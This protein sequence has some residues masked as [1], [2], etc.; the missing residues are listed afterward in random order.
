MKRIPCD[1]EFN[2]TP[3]LEEEEEEED[4]TTPDSTTQPQIAVEH[5]IRP[6]A[7]ITRKQYPQRE[8]VPTEFWK[9]Y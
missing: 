6:P 2:L 5:Y 8:R 4:F 3:K 9:K 7:Q 1:T